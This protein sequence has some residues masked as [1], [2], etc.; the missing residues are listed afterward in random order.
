MYYGVPVS[1]Y[2]LVTFDFGF[3]FDFDFEGYFNYI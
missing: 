3:D 2:I 1:D